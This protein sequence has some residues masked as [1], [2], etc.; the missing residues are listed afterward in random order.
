MGA[1]L[2]L[3]SRIHGYLTR[4]IYLGKV[5]SHTLTQF[6]ALKGSLTTVKVS[7]VTAPY[8]AYWGTTMVFRRGNIPLKFEQ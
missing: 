8:I 3:F 1:F 7:R 5:R 4:D 6:P 2:V